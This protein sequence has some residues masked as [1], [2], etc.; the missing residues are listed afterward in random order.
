VSLKRLLDLMAA[1]IGLAILLPFFLV[2]SLCIKFTSPGPI[3]FR[4]LRVGQ[5]GRPFRIFKFRTMVV[6]AERLGAQVSTGD[7]PRITRIGKF[8]RKFKVDELPQLINVV[9][10]EM[11]LV[12]PRPEVPR[13][14]EVFREDYRDILAVRPGI[15]DFASLA[16]KNENELLKGIPNP[17]EKYL[18]EIL[19]VKIGYYRKYLKEQSLATDLKLIVKTLWGIVR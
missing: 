3:F 7:D 1:L 10:G 13:Y 2:I 16:F 11:S 9:I 6:D 15:T 14:V 12:G 17:E 5:F 8:L 4:Q 18:T 19:P